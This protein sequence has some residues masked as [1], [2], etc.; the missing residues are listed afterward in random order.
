MLSISRF[1]EWLQDQAQHP[2]AEDVRRVDPQMHAVGETLAFDLFRDSAAGMSSSARLTR[3]ASGRATGSC[4]E[5]DSD[6]TIRL[7]RRVESSSMRQRWRVERLNRRWIDLVAQGAHLVPPAP[8]RGRREGR[9]SWSRTSK[10]YSRL[11]N[12][13]FQPNS[14]D[15]PL[16]QRIAGIIRSKLTGGGTGRSCVD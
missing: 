2:R 9:C 13:Q 14:M 12:R 8:L 1:D 11:M 16:D 3:R 15:A 10:L 4:A 7:A 6:S 5:R